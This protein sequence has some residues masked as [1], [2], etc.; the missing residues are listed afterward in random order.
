MQLTRDLIMDGC[1]EVDFRL[2][3]AIAF[4]RSHTLIKYDSMNVLFLR[5]LKT[6][7]RY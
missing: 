7:G 4:F 5:N 2:L 1:N 3:T 6:S